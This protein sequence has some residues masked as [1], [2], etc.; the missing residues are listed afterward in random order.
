M[1]AVSAS[2]ARAAQKHSSEA[3]KLLGHEPLTLLLG[4]QAAQ[5]SGD[6]GKAETA[7]N[8]MLENRDTRVVGLR[9]L[10]IEAQRKSDGTAARFYADEAYKLAPSADWAS[11]LTAARTATGWGPWLWWSRR[12]AGG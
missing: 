6:G 7:F 1:V 10:Y 11:W 5:L 3:Q 9:G 12:P 4:A 2:D 8:T